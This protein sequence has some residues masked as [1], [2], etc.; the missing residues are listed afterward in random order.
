MSCKD[1]DSFISDIK[2]QLL[3]VELG[4]ELGTSTDSNN[5]SLNKTKDRLEKVLEKANKVKSSSDN[6]TNLSLEKLLD[7]FT[8]E[9]QSPLKTMFISVIGEEFTYKQGN[10]EHTGIL[11]EVSLIE[12]TKSIKIKYTPKESNTKSRT[13]IF[14]INSDTSLHKTKQNKITIENIG[15]FVA[16][17][18]KVDKN[19]NSDTFGNTSKG[20]KE[21]EKASLE[22]VKDYVHG[23]KGKML[24][25]LDKLQETSYHKA[26]EE[27]FNYL[28][29]LIDIIPKKAF[30]KLALQIGKAVDEAKGHVNAKVMS[31]YLAPKKNPVRL[32]MSD[33]EVYTH[34]TLHSVIMF[35]YRSNTPE[36][37]KVKRQLNFIIKKALKHLTIEDFYPD[38]PTE[39]EKQKA[40]ELYEYIFASTNAEEEFLVHAITHKPLMNKLKNI[41]L[42]ETSET[43]F[44]DKIVSLLHTLF[45]IVFGNFSYVDKDK[46]L[47][48]HSLALALRLADINYTHAV[49]AENKRN[50]LAKVM[51]HINALDID[52][53]LW[54]ADMKK[55]LE[56]DF[57][58]GT[59]KQTTLKNVFH[60]L[61]ALSMS[62]TS[63]KYKNIIG[64]YATKLGMDINNP[65]RSYIRDMLINDKAQFAV[66]HL[67]NKK[68]I[69]DRER[70]T[71]IDIVRHRVLE[72]FKNGITNEQDKVL[73]T[74]LLE[75]NLAS[76]LGTKGYGKEE[77]SKVLRDETLLKEKKKELEKKILEKLPKA[78]AVWIINQARGLGYM[79]YSGESTSAQNI[80]SV[81]IANLVGFPFKKINIPTEIKDLIPQI[82]SLSALTYTDKTERLVLADLVDNE[83]EGV[84][85]VS[86]QYKAYT[87]LL[88]GTVFQ[89]ENSFI[90]GY[91]KHSYGDGYKV[92]IQGLNKKEYL[93]KK[94]FK[95][96]KTLALKGEKGE[97]LGIYLQGKEYVNEYQSGALSITNTDALHSIDIGNIFYHNDLNFSESKAKKLLAASGRQAKQLSIKL[98][99]EIKDDFSSLTKGLQYVN[100]PDESS[101]YVKRSIALPKS[102]LRK[103]LEEEVRASETL[104]RSFGNVIDIQKSVVHNIEVF[105]FLLKDM[106][107]NWN[108]KEGKLNSKDGMHEYVVLHRDSEDR[109]IKNIYFNLPSTIRRRL[110]KETDGVLAIR[111]DLFPL[112][113]GYEHYSISK[114]KLANKYLPEAAKTALHITEKLWID[115][116]KLSKRSVLLKLPQVLFSNLYS[117]IIFL[118][119]ELGEPKEVLRL[120]LESFRNVKD[121]IATAKEKAKYEQDLLEI[122][123][124]LLR[125]ISDEEKGKYTNKVEKLNVLIKAANKSLKKNPVHELVK[126]GMLQSVQEDLTTVNENPNLIVN[127]IGNQVEKLP[128]G[129]RTVLD[130]VYLTENT[131]YGKAAEEV[132]QISDL[133]G[134][135]VYNN[136]LIKKAERQANGKEKLPLWFVTNN[137]M[138]M[139]DLQYFNA[140]KKANYKKVLRGKERELFFKL[141][142]EHRKNVVLD[143]FINY[144]KPNGRIEEYLN[145]IGLFMFTKFAKRIQRTIIHQSATNPIKTLMALFTDAYLVNLDTIQEASILAKEWHTNTQG[146]GNYM[147]LYS[148]LDHVYNVTMPPVIRWF[149]NPYN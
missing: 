89:Q 19:E 24:E 83:Y 8:E 108:G 9:Y 44:V 62:V 63:I 40:K 4:I 15:N 53:S 128:S 51:D 1:I 109:F 31:L 65:I 118:I 25:T 66:E 146:P 76:L 127:F 78:Y 29:H 87:K 20:I 90:E 75:T 18:V 50:P 28:K 86:D 3:D 126:L 74:V 72:A 130:W 27:H 12:G 98:T 97:Q 17:V 48:E 137:E 106:Q 43:T 58:Y 35:A 41:T 100:T 113:V 39:V 68:Q 21:E 77:I 138:N 125:D 107:D 80:N 129:V 147:P 67:L 111:K 93:E 42:Q 91:L 114:N 123:G 26:D 22:E 32:S 121:Y 52:I 2:S 143:H 112:I 96:V 88:I 23:D 124:H 6:R 119:V 139:T 10:N 34:E 33:A 140:L 73:K 102:V 149:D 55:K 45:N 145:R 116:V 110:F 59:S 82:A 5:Y 69:V 46:N 11:Q 81:S 115:F 79:M 99:K 84:L 144:E 57:K 135:V 7:A 101:I 71:K 133:I 142:E 70:Q 131:A 61:R 60:I 136:R 85:D 30:P 14:D 49:E 47:Y 92:V 104:A 134:R 37:K 95:L 103:E 148:P 141:A 122:K 54:I 117:A 36:A 105:E 38:N 94:G 16:N 132:L 13:A 64:M 56:V 120:Y